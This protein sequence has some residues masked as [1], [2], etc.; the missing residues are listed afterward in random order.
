MKVDFSLPAPG[1]AVEKK[2]FIP[3]RFHNL[4]IGP[5]LL[6]IE[7][8]LIGA[9]G[10]DVSVYRIAIGSLFDYFKKSL[11]DKFLNNAGSNTHL[12]HRYLHILGLQK[13]IQ[14]FQLLHCVGSCL[15]KGFLNFFNG[16]H[17][18][19]DLDVLNGIFSLIRRLQ[20]DI[21][22]GDE[23]IKAPFVILVD[24]LNLVI[25]KDVLSVNLMFRT[26]G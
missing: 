17:A 8:M 13:I 12:V 10:C 14:Q 18:V 7:E 9:I 6:Y 22:L 23:L 24:Y 4:I 20:G 21:T 11:I 26:D 25:S 16:S 3:L 2:G 1:H 5:L 15:V 19:D